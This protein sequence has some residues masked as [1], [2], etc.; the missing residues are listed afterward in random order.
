MELTF[1]EVANR[2]VQTALYLAAPTLALSLA[3]GFLVSIFQAVTSIQEQTLT[4]VPKIF[5]TGLAMVIFGP[6]M[7]NVLNSFATT[8]FGNLEQYVK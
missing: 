7:F 3:V 6:W 4:F 8:L 2:G 5:V 1:L